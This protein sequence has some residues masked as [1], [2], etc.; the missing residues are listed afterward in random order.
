MNSRP[1]PGTD[2]PDVRITT[3]A[4]HEHL[5]HLLAVSDDSAP[6]LML[7]H[8]MRDHHGVYR[9]LDLTAVKTLRH[10]GVPIDFLHPPSQR[11]F[12]SEYSVE[13]VVV[14]LIFVRDALGEQAVQELARYLW[15]S[16][17]NVSIAPQAT[18]APVTVELHR[19]VQD[20]ERRE[21]EGLRISGQDAEHVV[22]A[23][24]RALRQELPPSRDD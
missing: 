2:G 17:R 3:F 12:Q 24:M 5:S 16:I 8:R 22:E 4:P 7:P 11:T 18:Q 13:L 10:R 19:Y 1:S 6:V 15:D 21:L 14:L 9:D 20:G 23:F